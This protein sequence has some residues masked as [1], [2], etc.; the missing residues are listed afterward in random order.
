MSATRKKQPATRDFL[1]KDLN[2]NETLLDK[3]LKSAD[4]LDLVYQYSLPTPESE[5]KSDMAEIQ[6][7]QKN[8]NVNQNYNKNITF[9]SNIKTSLVTEAVEHV[10]WARADEAVLLVE[11]NPT[12]MDMVI[13]AKDPVGRRIEGTLLQIAAMTGDVNLWKQSNEQ[14]NGMVERLIVAGKLS[15]EEIVKQLTPIFSFNAMRK[16]EKRNSSI[17]TA[18]K[19]F[20]EGLIKMDEIEKETFEGFQKR[21]KPLIDTFRKSLKPNPNKVMTSGYIFDIQILSQALRWYKNNC[22][23]LG[24]GWQDW[25]CSIFMINGF[26]SLQNMLSVRDLQ[27]AL[28]GVEKNIKNK[29]IPPRSL[30]NKD[31][32]IFYN[33]NSSLGLDFYLGGYC[34]CKGLHKLVRHWAGL[35]YLSYETQK[36][37]IDLR[38]RSV[39]NLLH[40]ISCRCVM[41]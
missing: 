26:G 19:E 10:L 32:Y 11:K 20:T 39:E 31:G 38:N 18:L 6:A 8:K 16:N 27:A 24:D 33:L 23:R 25:K 5:K 35:Q 14:D 17:L 37:F 7:S 40:S 30:F 22:N 15:N 36:V 13:E 34:P 28:A 4:L 2:V 3:T 29:V 41:L 9:F 1:I 21:C 12:I